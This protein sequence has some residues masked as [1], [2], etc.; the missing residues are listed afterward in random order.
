MTSNRLI[1]NS[2]RDARKI[3]YFP[4]KMKGKCNDFNV[5]LFA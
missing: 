5:D 3:Q 2:F 4:V 1:G